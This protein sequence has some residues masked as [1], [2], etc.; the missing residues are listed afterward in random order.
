MSGESPS[1]KSTVAPESDR[2]G[3]PND[4]I[5]GIDLGTTNSLVAF[6]DAAGPRILELDAGP[7]R[8]L[9]R[10]SDAGPTRSEA[11]LVPSVLR[12]RDD[13]VEAVGREAAAGLEDHATRTVFSVKRYMGRRFDDRRAD[14]EASPY[15][16]VANARGL[17]GVEIDGR[18]RSPEEISADLLAHLR[19]GL[20]GTVRTA[21]QHPALA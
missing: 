8:G 11:G 15:R 10:G 17:A 6:A 16:V 2:A 19:D 1:S 14:A 9:D 5:V 20:D 21:C 3:V 12:Y 7:D 4:P 13:V 18:V